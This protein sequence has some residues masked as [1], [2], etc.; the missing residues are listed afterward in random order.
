MDERDFET[1]AR[2]WPSGP[3]E[4]RRKTAAETGE[5]KERWWIG[6][7]ERERK[8]DLRPS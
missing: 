7:R 5:K 4:P 1:G 3:E 2:R 6:E 8:T